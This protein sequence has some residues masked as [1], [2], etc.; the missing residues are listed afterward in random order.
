MEII[1]RAAVLSALKKIR[2]LLKEK[3]SSSNSYSEKKTEKADIFDES[4]LDVFIVHKLA[5]DVK[6]LTQELVVF[7]TFDMDEAVEESDGFE[8]EEVSQI[9]H[10]NFKWVPV[11]QLE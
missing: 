8:G 4:G 9:L 1:H 7:S 5:E 3:W 2:A 6:L 10:A 11:V